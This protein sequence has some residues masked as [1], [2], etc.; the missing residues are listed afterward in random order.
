MM[1]QKKK[2]DDWWGNVEASDLN[3]S[4]ARKHAQQEF[5]EVHQ[6]ARFQS[7]VRPSKKK[8]YLEQQQ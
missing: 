5:G 8:T 6:A 7:T 3:Y 4:I 2:E 1:R